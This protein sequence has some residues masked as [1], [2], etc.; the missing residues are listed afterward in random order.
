MSLRSLFMAAAR[1]THHHLPVSARRVMTIAW[2]GKSVPFT[3]ETAIDTNIFKK[4]KQSG[5]FRHRA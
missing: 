1:E 4:E 2:L 3:V 5:N